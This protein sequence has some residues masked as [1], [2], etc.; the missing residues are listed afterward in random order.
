MVLDVL[1]WTCGRVVGFTEQRFSSP[2]F[3]GCM[4]GMALRES[5]W[6]LLV[7]FVAE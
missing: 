3:V 2:G 6:L 5:F 1:C 7:A 4:V